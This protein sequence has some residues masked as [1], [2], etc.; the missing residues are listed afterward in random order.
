MALALRRA[1]G[2]ASGRGAPPPRALRPGRR[3]PRPAPA[4]HRT[5]R[6]LDRHRG[7]VR[8]GPPIDGSAAPPGRP[9]AAQDLRLLA[10]LLEAGVPLAVA[11]GT[12]A[13]APT[14]R[15]T[16]DRLAAAARHL[17]T[18]APVAP[19]LGA[20]APHVA[21][22][23]AAGERIGRL[24]VTVAAAADLAERLDA[25]ARRIR[26]ALAY[27]ALVAVV[28]SAVVAVVVATVV[29]QMAT[30]FAD[31]GSELP[32]ATR[33]V[34]RL[35]ELASSSGAVGLLIAGLSLALLRRRRGAGGGP[36]PWLPGG[37]GQPLAIA[38]GLRV[39]A[40]L[41]THGVPLA[42]A[43][44]VAADGAGDP[45]VRTALTEA[46]DR[47]RS[48]RDLVGSEGLAALLPEAD[49]AVLAV[50]ES[51][52][53]LAPQLVRVADRRLAALERRLELVAT[54]AEPFLVLV[55]G[56]VV[57]A[58]VAALYLPSF[59]VLELV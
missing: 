5:G 44:G 9:P 8:G 31:L 36:V 7:R 59:R 26:A 43:L 27:P 13:R 19:V 49:R 21:A 52:G 46:A 47:V 41:V 32:V 39:A 2:F 24:A 57:G 15:R 22:L 33:A 34:V 40:T 10:E 53:L 3:G 14:D 45:R 55:V 50:G 23:L 29:P 56:A 30:T 20:G 16:G 51:R 4:A 42:D 1:R 37:L 28:A 12:V 6:S 25:A 17:A 35:A 18:G 58:V 11:L 48:G 38:V 54:L